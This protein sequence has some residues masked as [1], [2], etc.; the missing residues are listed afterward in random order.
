MLSAVPDDLTLLR[1]HLE[2]VWNLRLPPLAHG[3]LSLWVDDD[4]PL[5]AN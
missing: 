3:A 2:A 4:G 5:P 1:M